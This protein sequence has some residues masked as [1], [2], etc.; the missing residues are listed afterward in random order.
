MENT[1]VTPDMVTITFRRNRFFP[2]LVAIGTI[3][4]IGFGVLAGFLVWGRGSA[5]AG[6]AAAAAAEPQQVRRFDIPTEGF[7]SIGPEDAPITIVEFSDFQ[8]PYCERWHSQVYEPLM[9]AYPGKIRLVYRN[10]PLTQIHPQAMSAAEAALCAGEQDAY[11]QYH[12]KLFENYDVLG[13]NLYSQIASSLGL[14]VTAFKTCMSEHRYQDDIEADLSFSTNL[15]VQSTPTFFINGIPIIGAQ[16]LTAFQ[17]I[18]DDEL[19]GK[20]PK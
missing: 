11:W 18:I 16:P 8:C 5:A 1:P 20:N 13:E 12:D 15:G 10:F 6:N 14:D 9:A 19:A 7:P 2:S 4:G 3:I 17:Q